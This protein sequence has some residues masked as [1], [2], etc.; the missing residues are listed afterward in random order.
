[1][2]LGFPPTCPKCHV[3][4]NCEAGA[5]GGVPGNELNC[6]K[7][8][9]RRLRVSMVFDGYSD[10][11]KTF[12][13]DCETGRW[14]G[15]FL[16]DGDTVDFQFYFAQ[17]DAGVCWFYLESAFL[18]L[19][20]GSSDTRLKE[21]LPGDWSSYR[22]TRIA[23]CENPEFTFADV[24]IPALGL[25]TISTQIA[26]YQTIN[27]AR[28]QRCEADCYDDGLT[29]RDCN[30]F[31][32]CVCITFTDVDESFTERVCWDEAYEYWSIT[33]AANDTLTIGISCDTVTGESKLVL[34]DPYNGTT[35]STAAN[36]PEISGSWSFT[37]P[38]TSEVSVSIICDSCGTC[39]GGTPDTCGCPDG[40]P[41]TLYATFSPGTSPGPPE[42]YPKSCTGATGSIT[43]RWDDGA[44][45]WLGFGTPFSGCSTVTYLRL[46]CTGSTQM[47]LEVGTSWAALNDAGTE[48]VTCSP[49]SGDWVGLTF[50]LA[51]DTCCGTTGEPGTAD[52]N[53]FDIAITE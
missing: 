52:Y 29:C 14:T 48:T 51:T 41:A 4:V 39:S 22:T 33:T 10:Q 1:M 37:K 2:P 26:D 15:F 53:I 45:A 47:K 5:Q 35:R 17:D 43:L 49:F 36:C 21:A 27:P 31:C 23:S 11:C 28:L 44:G 46:T 6:C 18:D 8:V 20:I 42:P 16:I 9:P 25:V 40:I 38:D 32:R 7:C 30:C 12:A 3:R 24:D 19:E 50:L 13:I 34:S